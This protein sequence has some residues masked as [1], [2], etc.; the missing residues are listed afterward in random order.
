MKT[1]M[2]GNVKM[3]DP[4]REVSPNAT[5]LLLVE[6]EVIVA[7]DVRRRLESLGYVVL[8]LATRGPDAIEMAL[9]LQP[10]LVL[11][12]IGLR[13]GMDGIET[14]RMIHQ[15][16]DVPIIFASAYSDDATLQ[17]ARAAQPHGFVLKPFEERELRTA[18]EMAIHAHT[19]EQRIRQNEDFLRQV[20]EVLPDGILV[21][22]SAR[23]VELANSSFFKIFRIPETTLVV[24]ERI[25]SGDEGHFNVLADPAAFIRRMDEI[26]KSG[27]PTSQEPV[28]T[29]DGRK[30]LLTYMPFRGSSDGNGHLWDFHDAGLV[31]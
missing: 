3:G 4:G 25:H 15:K 19:A 26:V 22:D 24:G 20:I 14:A 30:I 8:G 29:T 18:I 11:M 13:G 1:M 12:D 6:D 27:T 16:V 21:E 2:S 31:V 9:K 28:F 5:T 23:R 17:R 7:E 10:N